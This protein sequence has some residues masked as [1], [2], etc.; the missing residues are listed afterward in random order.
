MFC[1]N[2]TCDDCRTHLAETLSELINPT[3]ASTNSFKIQ[4]LELVRV[5]KYVREYV[6][7][8]GPISRDQ[9]CMVTSDPHDNLDKAIEALLKDGRL[10][11]DDNQD[12][13]INPQ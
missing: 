8:H 12:L 9:L 5:I 3:R 7:D 2:C 11:R 1:S 6:K 10:K 4:L 13:V